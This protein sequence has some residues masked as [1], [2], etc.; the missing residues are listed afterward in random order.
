MISD[1]HIFPDANNQE[2][3]LSLLNPLLRGL[4]VAGIEQTKIDGDYYGIRIML[5]NRKRDRIHLLIEPTT[6][7][8]KTILKTSLCS[9]S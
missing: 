3:K 8:G 6:Q 7:D 4:K 5:D 2:I 1:K 9:F